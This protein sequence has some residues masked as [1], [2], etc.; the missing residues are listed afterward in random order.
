[1]A[2]QNI[3]NFRRG[4][5]RGVVVKSGTQQYVG[6][7][8]LPSAG[9]ILQQGK[10]NLERNLQTA[11]PLA[12]GGAYLYTS[13]YSDEA[14]A[15]ARKRAERGDVISQLYVNTAEGLL[16][17]ID[18]T[19]TNAQE[20][21]SPVL[22]FT[23]GV[24]SQL[25]YT[26]A[27][28]PAYLQAVNLIQQGEPGIIGKG[29]NSVPGIIT[30]TV[31]YAKENPIQFAG[32]LVGGA[33]L[34]GAGI[35]AKAGSVGKAAKNA[36]KVKT[37]KTV[38]DIANVGYVKGAKRG[39]RDSTQTP[40]PKGYDKV[41]NRPDKTT[42]ET[43]LV[44]QL[45]RSAFGDSI[46][47]KNTPTGNLSRNNLL[48]VRDNRASIRT[49][50]PNNLSRNAGTTKQQNIRITGNVPSQFTAVVGKPGYQ[51]IVEFQIKGGTYTASPKSVKQNIPSA[52]G[53]ISYNDVAAR[54]VAGKDFVFK[55]GSNAVVA[56]V[57]KKYGPNMASVVDSSYYDDPFGKKKKKK[58][59]KGIDL[60]DMLPRSI[61]FEEK[62]EPTKGRMEENY[63]EI[64][65]VVADF[66]DS[67]DKMTKSESKPKSSNLTY[68]KKG[69]KDKPKRETKAGSKKQTRT[70]WQDRQRRGGEAKA[71]D[72][73]TPEPTP[74]PE[75][76]STDK[77]A[78]KSKDKPK[79]ETQ[80]RSK[81]KPRTRYEGRE[82]PKRQ[83]VFSNANSEGGRLEVV[84]VGA[85]STPKELPANISPFKLSYIT[86]ST[87]TYQ[88]ISFL[89]QKSKVSP[90]DRSKSQDMDIPISQSTSI[91]RGLVIP[92]SDYSSLSK[93]GELAKSLGIPQNKVTE[94]ANVASVSATLANVLSLPTSISTDIP[95]PIPIP[96]PIPKP[97]PEPD[98]TPKP[99]PEPNPK[100]DPTPKPKPKPNPKPD[101][102]PKPKPR[103]DSDSPNT[104]RVRGRTPIIKDTDKD[105]ES[106]RI[107]RR[108]VDTTKTRRIRKRKDTEPEEEEE[109]KKKKA[110]KTT[111]RSYIQKT[112]PLPW[113]TDAEDT[114]WLRKDMAFMRMPARVKVT[115]VRPKLE[116][117]NEKVKAFNIAR[118]KLRNTATQSTA[119]G[120][121]A[122][123]TLKRLYEAAF[124][125]REGVV[126][127]IEKN[128]R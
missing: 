9:Q 63:K 33:A 115:E 75:P 99:K 45:P 30:D 38:A 15:D 96:V 2:V 48:G 39:F 14:L 6:G 122:L 94:I 22:K 88:N 5:Q 34:G 74:K 78:S 42:T 103:P 82:A 56:D 128:R 12:M 68:T 24:I 105:T 67:A 40:T 87:P 60:S 107:R 84:E 4:R 28:V 20:S 124:E 41:N 36:G 27:Q 112:N 123:A 118:K 44:T 119:E 11:N 106:R 90:L 73:P 54:L 10:Q 31:D 26:I 80:A 98:P 58:K 102:T 126:K 47:S 57:N 19:M 116:A 46:P 18:D 113:E 7:G 62:P 110:R 16:K 111:S 85:T 95:T 114:S 51:S 8:N 37:G 71:A 17:D 83:V 21:G 3:N 121:K 50:Q 49:S 101:P 59:K 92:K 77:P 104:R 117:F 93:T 120:R 35:G 13:Q 32:A 70:S 76:K 97:T 72:K 108:D 127:A 100:P 64:P 79:K 109:K 53:E 55:D 1:M 23:S 86:Q 65:P 89:G 25:P 125:A 29:Y 52:V 61:I 91:S 81:E 66:F 43:K 69:T